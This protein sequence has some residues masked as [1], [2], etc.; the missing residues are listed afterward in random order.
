MIPG[1]DVVDLS[2]LQFALTVSLSICALDAWAC[3]YPCYHG[4]GI[5]DDGACHLETDG[6]ILGVIIWY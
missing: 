4:N 1:T 2:R 3:R 6:K 5:C